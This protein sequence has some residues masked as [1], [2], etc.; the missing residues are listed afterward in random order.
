MICATGLVMP[1]HQYGSPLNSGT[2][3]LYHNFATN[4]FFNKKN[5]FF[6]LAGETS[7]TKQLDPGETHRGMI[8]SSPLLFVQH[9][10]NS[11]VTNKNNFPSFYPVVYNTLALFGNI[12]NQH[13][14]TGSNAARLT[15]HKSRRLGN[16]CQ[17]DK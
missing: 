14:R 5:F 10:Y 9:F 13:K 2:K 17:N 1:L 3:G 15:H 11:H 7:G 8:L 6:I 4:S 12:C 16:N